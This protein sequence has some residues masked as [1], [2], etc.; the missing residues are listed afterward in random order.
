MCDISKCGL[1]PPARK[2]FVDDS[3]LWK[4]QEDNDPKHTSKLA[5]NWK[6]N[7]GVYE[8]HWPSISPDLVL[9]RNIWQLFKMNLRTK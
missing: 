2:Q 5:V 4:L 9:M 3:A 6:R 1:L 8:I 7:N